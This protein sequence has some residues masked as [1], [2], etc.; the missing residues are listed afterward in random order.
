MVFPVGMVIPTV[1]RRMRKPPWYG[2]S[3]WHGI[4]GGLCGPRLANELT[5]VA[6]RFI[7]GMPVDWLSYARGVQQLMDHL[8]G[9]LGLPQL[10]EMTDHLTKYFKQGRRKRGESMG[11]YITRKVE[12]YSRAK[13]AL[14]RVLKTYRSLNYITPKVFYIPAQVCLEQSLGR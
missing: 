10:P 6:R 5:G 12:V 13:Q 1:S 2:N 4:S 14:S 8:R 11:E 3:Q 7:L 9:S